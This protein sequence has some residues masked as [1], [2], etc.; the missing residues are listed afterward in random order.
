MPDNFDTCLAFTLKDKA[1][2]PMIL[3][4]PAGPPTWASP[5]RHTANGPTTRA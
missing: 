4:I 2:I 3:P 1:A 5:W